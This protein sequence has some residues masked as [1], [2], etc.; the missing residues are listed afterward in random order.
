MLRPFESSSLDFA[1]ILAAFVSVRRGDGAKNAEAPVVIAN[2]IARDFSIVF[3]GC[4][5][6]ERLVVGCSCVSGV[7]EFGGHPQ[8][9]VQS[10]YPNY[11]P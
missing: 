5:R 3:C 6:G 2:K 8:T 4:L 1:L 10:F 11:L 7:L 9:V